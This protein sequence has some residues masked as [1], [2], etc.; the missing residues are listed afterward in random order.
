MKACLRV[1]VALA[2]VAL[3]GLPLLAQERP[4]L[5]LTV[6]DEGGGVMVAVRVTL[7]PASGGQPREVATTREGV[8]VFTGLPPGEYKLTVTAPGF[9][10]VEQNVKIGSQALDPMRITMIVEVTEVVEV[11]EFRR[12]MPKREE[13][14]QNAD[15]VNVDDDILVGVPMAI[16]GD[17]IVQFLSRFM[18]SAA[19]LPSIVVD[20]Q[21]ITRLNLPPRAIDEIVVNKNPYSAEYRRPG[22]ARV[23]V[24]SQDGSQ[25]HHHGDATFVFG[26]SAISARN[27]FVQEKPDLQEMVG[28]FGWSGPLRGVKGSYLFAAEVGGDRTTGVI[29]ATTL[30]GPVTAFIPEQQAETFWTGRIDLEPSDRLDLTFRYE[31][32][33]ETEKNGA[34][35]GITL[36]E[37]AIDAGNLKQDFYFGINH[38]LSAGFVHTP[39]IR[40]AYAN[41]EEG[42]SPLGPKLLVRGAFEGGYS[43][44]HRREKVIEIDVQDI[45]TWRKGRNV[46]RFGVH[47]APTFLNV[48]DGDNFGGTYEFANLDMFAAGRPFVFK[49]N[50]GNPALRYRADVGDAHFQH[51]FKFRPDFTFMTGVRY[52]WESLVKDNNNVAPRIAFSFSPG[53]RKFALRG[54][55]GMFYERLGR[56]GYERVELLGGNRVRELVFNNPSYPNALDGTAVAP[57]KT[58][59]RF[60]P[61]M[62][63]P[64]MAQ[65]SIGFD[66]Q[67]GLE[68]S[69][70]VEYIHLRGYNL[71]RVR[72][73]NT[74]I[75]GVRPDPS[76]QNIIQIEP[77]GLMRNNS[78]HLTLQGE[79][80]QFEGHV[81]YTYSK[82]LNDTPGTS[83]GGGMS[84]TLPA[85]SF[86]P[87]EEWG[88]ADFD[89]RHRLAIAGVYEMPRDFQMGL[90]I[91]WSSGLPY[92]ITTGFDDNGDSIAND[93]PIGFVRNAGQ[94]P[95]FFQVDARFAK[96]WEAKRPIDQQEDPAEFELYLDVFNVFNTI[97]YLDIIGVQTSPR[98]GLPTL[99]D[100]GR[101]LQAGLTYSF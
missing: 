40:V 22:R 55:A 79:M 83:A 85:N 24:I 61:V 6:Q 80:G 101:Q 60:A 89:R 74:P 10:T 30:D 38:I 70:S 15:A 48:A 12:P 19:G 43:Q 68:T 50:E 75:N 44:L 100:K 8:A 46:F 27:P 77:T 23:E 35:G 99:A 56:S 14:D 51:E 63:T 69:L 62:E 26:N 37:L 81:A 32:E 47:Y 90:I 13:I 87:R 25:S 41:A 97:N 59:Y 54:G 33:N 98:F 11:E 91:D 94:S 29:N 86:N 96:V 45:A 88:R 36:P 66:Q 9:K 5:R 95:R 52:D 49:I 76:F 65:G 31:Y 53:A 73:L 67:L 7:A 28:E 71:F 17:R 1:F 92:E 34:V 58:V 20:G 42:N 84:L 82:T 3:F 72:D 18:N 39:K 21:E 93:R 16:R 64:Y 2:V 78:V 57:S 4:T